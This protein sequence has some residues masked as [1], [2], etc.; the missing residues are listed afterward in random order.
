MLSF[1]KTEVLLGIFKFAFQSTKLH[2][3]TLHYTTLHYITLHYTTFTGSYSPGRTFGFPFRGFLI[4]HIQAHGRT[5]LDEWSARRR[6]LYLHRTTKTY[7]HNRQT[8]MPLA[9]FEPATPATKRPQTYAL[10]RVA[11]GIGTLHYIT[12]HYITLHY[13]TL[14]YATLRYTTLHYTTIHYITLH[15]TTLHYTTL[16]YITLHYITLNYTTLHYITLRYTTL[17][18]INFTPVFC[19]FGTWTLTSENEHKSF[20]SHSFRWSR[21]HLKIFIF[22][23]QITL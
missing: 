13:A 11:T 12:L 14:R 1:V 17:H 18:T 2:Y 9:G 21:S 4:T 15:Y 6:G 16:Y 20:G 22:L 19:G 10:E 7:K 8:S 3:T 23:R 5:P